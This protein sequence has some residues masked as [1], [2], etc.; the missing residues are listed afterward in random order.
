[1]WSSCVWVFI[2]HLLYMCIL[3]LIHPFC[4]IETFQNSVTVTEGSNVK[5]LSFLW[6]ESC[7]VNILWGFW[8]KLTEK[9]SSMQICHVM[10]KLD[11]SMKDW[12][13]N[14]CESHLYYQQSSTDTSYPWKTLNMSH[15][16]LIVVNPIAFCELLV[17][18][19]LRKKP[20]GWTKVTVRQHQ[21]H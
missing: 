14:T 18:H 17:S 21:E 6:S 13:R 9:S 20:A 10:H 12:E 4:F 15:F 8:K 7:C 1:M 19:L 5:P 11:L 3:W 2:L 16:V